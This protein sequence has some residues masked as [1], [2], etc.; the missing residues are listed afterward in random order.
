MVHNSFELGK[1]IGFLSFLSCLS[2]SFHG[3]FSILGIPHQNPP[4]P[5]SIV[6][7]L[8]II[9]SFYFTTYACAWLIGLGQCPPPVSSFSLSFVPQTSFSS[10]RLPHSAT[11]VLS[12]PTQLLCQRPSGVFIILQVVFCLLMAFN[13]LLPKA[14]LQI[15]FELGKL[16][17]TKQLLWLPRCQTW[18]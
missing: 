16:S 17:W 6:L 2:V 4:S 14:G 13:S 18:V 12:V 10:H 3:S 5:V 8:L 11:S 7:K 9:R 15:T 1:S